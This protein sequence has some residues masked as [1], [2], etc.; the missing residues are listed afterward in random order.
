L[1]FSKPKKEQYQRCHGVQIVG[2]LVLARAY[3][4]F[5]TALHSGSAS[6]PKNLENIQ[7]GK[8]NKLSFGA[9]VDLGA[10]D[11]DCRVSI[12]GSDI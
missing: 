8:V 1:S 7:Y 4:T 11:N 2:K 5:S 6:P 3:I 12:A 9:V 10:F